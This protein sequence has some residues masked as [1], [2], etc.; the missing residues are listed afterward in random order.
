MSGFP[1]RMS[2]FPFRMSGFPFRMSGFPLVVSLSNHRL[3]METV[4]F[5]LREKTYQGMDGQ[6][7]S[8]SV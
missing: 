7:A 5:T 3:R 6:T 2:G 8:I 1:L 4:E